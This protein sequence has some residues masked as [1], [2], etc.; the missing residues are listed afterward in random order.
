MA[1]S[2][3]RAPDDAQAGWQTLA[4]WEPPLGVMR[5]TGPQSGVAPP[6]SPAPAQNAEQYRTLPK[7]RHAPPGQSLFDAQT[8]P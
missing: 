4:A 5:K 7:S 6:Q 2:M 1:R 3:G 8:S